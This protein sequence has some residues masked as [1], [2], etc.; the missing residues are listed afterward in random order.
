MAIL[1]AQRSIGQNA[2]RSRSRLWISDK[3]CD[4]SKR[5]GVPIID[6]PARPDSDDMKELAEGGDLL[7]L[8]TKPDAQPDA[9]PKHLALQVQGPADNCAALP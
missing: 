8:P 5:A 9:V 1:T 3:P 7:I 4:L 2:D 6:T